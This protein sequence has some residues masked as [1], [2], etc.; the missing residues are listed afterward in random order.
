MSPGGTILCAAECR[1]GLPE[2]GRY[3][4]T[5]RSADSLEDLLHDIEHRTAAVHDQW[6]VQIQAL[7]QRKATVRVHTSGI[8]AEQLTEAHFEPAPDL[9]AAV[10]ESLAVAGTGA[11][12]CVL[13]EGPQT[14]PYL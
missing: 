14:I 4:E 10:A 13:P 2:H 3:A 7:I 9:A 5:L 12:L 6:Q 8:T 1:D 11:T